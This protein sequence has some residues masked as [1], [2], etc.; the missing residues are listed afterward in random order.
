VRAFPNGHLTPRK[1]SKK[2]FGKIS[3]SEVRNRAFLSKG[4]SREK[5]ERAK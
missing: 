4:N 2:G 3:I 1:H 5:A